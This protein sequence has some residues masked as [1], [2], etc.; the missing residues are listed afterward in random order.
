LPL[1]LACAGELVKGTIA[2]AAAAIATSFFFK[3]GLLTFEK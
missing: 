3:R 1:T 2:T